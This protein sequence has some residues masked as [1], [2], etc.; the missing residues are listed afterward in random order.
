MATTKNATPQDKTEGKAKAVE[1]RPVQVESVYSAEEFV[2]NANSVFNVRSECV[3]AALK[4]AN[5]TN[6]TITKAKQIVEKF[7]TKEVK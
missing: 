2:A 4:A 5:V 6:C 7:M 1:T 3:A